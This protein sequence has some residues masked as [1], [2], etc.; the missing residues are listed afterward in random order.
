LASHPI[1]C[2]VNADI[3]LMHDILEAVARVPWDR[4]LLLGQRWDL[5]LRD[6]RAFD[7]M[8]WEDELRREARERGSL[9]GHTGVDYYVYRK[10]MWGEI[11]PFAVGRYMYDNWLIWRVRSMSVPVI[12]A[13]EVVTSIHQNHDRTY[14]SMGMQPPVGGDDYVRGIEARI[15]TRLG[16]GR[17]RRYTLR[18][19]TWRL[20][21]RG[22]NRA[23]TV[24]HLLGRL[25]TA[26]RHLTS[27]PAWWVARGG[28]PE[29]W[30]AVGQGGDR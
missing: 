5:D 15:N 7:A 25:R 16:G 30:E 8:G 19:A 23:V 18:D 2:Y 21:A 4:F 24:W 3:I 17:A 28:S 29:P 20:T 6:E 10:G 1:L 26:V 12:D 22:I 27:L 14:S 9:H 11:P 13:T